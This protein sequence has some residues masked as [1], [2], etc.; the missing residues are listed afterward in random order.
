MEGF[1][2]GVGGRVVYLDFFKFFNMYFFL[3][4]NSKRGLFFFLILVVVGG[5]DNVK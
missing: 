3:F 4:K 2:L 1:E 5:G